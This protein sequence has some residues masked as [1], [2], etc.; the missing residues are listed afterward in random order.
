ML[1]LATVAAA[2]GLCR[3]WCD[4]PCSELNGEVDQECGGCTKAH[5]CH[6]SAA[7]WVLQAGRPQAPRPASTSDE[8]L[9]HDR[10]LPAPS[11]QD[12]ARIDLLW[13]SAV[14]SAILLP[15]MDNDELELVIA[16]RWNGMMATLPDDIDPE[17]ANELFHDAHR[18]QLVKEQSLASYTSCESLQCEA[19][20]AASSAWPQLLNSSGFHKL[21]AREVGLVWRHLHRYVGQ[22]GLAGPPSPHALPSEALHVIKWSTWATHHR[23]GVHH[24]EHGHAGSQFSGVYYVKS[25]GAEELNAGGGLLRLFDPRAAAVQRMY[26]D[27]SEAQR[28]SCTFQP[29]A[30]LLL[31]WPSYL[32]HEVTPTVGDSARISLP[33]DLNIE[34]PSRRPR[35]SSGGVLETHAAVPLSPPKTTA[36]VG[37]NGLLWRS[38]AVPAEHRPGSADDNGSVGTGNDRIAFESRWSA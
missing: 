8:L 5:R 1:V 16:E 2:A 27:A 28:S 25:P 26:D 19:R 24:P 33:F 20:V 22:L 38:T 7:D 36:G 13:A 35:D 14:Y 12:T 31:I 17:E 6:P 34:A 9:H 15:E 11:I 21:F 18:P 30:G 3:E 29:R 4:S 23:G 37:P 10:Q 32:T